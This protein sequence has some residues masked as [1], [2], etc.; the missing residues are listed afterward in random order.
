VTGDVGGML[1]LVAL[2]VVG[3]WTTTVLAADSL[4]F[5]NKVWDA[6]DHFWLVLG[7]IAAIFFIADSQMAQHDTDFRATG[8][9]IQRASGYLLKQVET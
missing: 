1:S 6:Y 7:L 2:L 8:N 9:D 5:R 3:G 4:A